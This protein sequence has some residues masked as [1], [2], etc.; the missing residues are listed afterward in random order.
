[1]NTIQLVIEDQDAGSSD[2]VYDLLDR[3]QKKR[4]ISLII[5]CIWA[6]VDAIFSGTYG[7]IPG[8]KSVEMKVA[9]V[10]Y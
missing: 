9:I 5:I 7:L 4:K 8:N 6:L 10:V 3:I 1:M 2:E